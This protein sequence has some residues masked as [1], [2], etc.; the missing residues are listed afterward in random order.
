VTTSRDLQVIADRLID[1]SNNASMLEPMSSTVSG[2]DS[3]SAYDILGYIA[4]HRRG[5]G[6]TQVGRKIGFTNRT[7]W[8]LFGVDRP[9]W[10]HMWST[11]VT[12]AAGNT[13]VRLDQFVQPRIEPEVVF[14]LRD[15]PPRT[16]SP[17]EVLRS[18][19][20]MAAGFEIVHCHF[21]DW[22]FTVA[23]ATADFGVHGA[24]VVGT[25]LVIDDDNRD[26][27][28][29]KL[30]TFELTLSRDGEAVDR[31]LGANVLDGPAHALAHLIRVLDDQPAHQPLGAGEI[32]TTGTITNMW[33]IAIGER[34]TSDYGS[35]GLHGPSVSFE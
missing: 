1:A 22:K 15:R 25:P 16:A 9:M 2:F 10:A 3:A 14:K 6:W 18:V 32:I 31:G 24:L 4:A 34:W 35:L 17:S 11:T 8:E 12:H 28:A 7:I 20:W 26:A 27:I 13:I 33:T 5:Q 19:E 30:S 23:D 29:A 21:P